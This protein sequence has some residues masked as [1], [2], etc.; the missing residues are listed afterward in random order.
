MPRLWQ[1]EHVAST[2]SLPVPSGR[3]IGAPRPR[4]WASA[5]A[6]TPKARL[7]LPIEVLPMCRVILSAFRAQ[8][9]PIHDFRTRLAT[10][11]LLNFL[12]RV[13]FFLRFLMDLIYRTR[14][15][16][17]ALPATEYASATMPEAGNML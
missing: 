5:V 6:K 13:A 7:A 2:R 14:G 8:T 1:R 11:R 4:P 17:P 10:R 16:A 12:V 9:V 15:A 3:L